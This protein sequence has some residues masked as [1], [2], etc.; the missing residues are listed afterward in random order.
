M[1][2][3]IVFVLFLF[4]F[5]YSFVHENVIVNE[6]CN[7]GFHPSDNL[8]ISTTRL[9][10]YTSTATA[11]T[12]S[13]RDGVPIAH[14]EAPIIKLWKRFQLYFLSNNSL[15]STSC[16]N[17][18]NKF[19]KGLKRNEYW[20]FKMLDATAKLPSGI[21]SG[22]VNQFG[23][24]DGC[25]SVVEAQY[26]LAE[27]NLDSV[28]SEHY[29]QYKNL[30]HSYYPFK[31]TFEDPQ[32]RVPDFTTIKWGIC[33]PSE[34]T[35]KE[36]EV[37]LK[38]EFG[39]K[40]K[41]RENM[42]RRANQGSRPLSFGDYVAR[43]FFMTL[44]LVVIVSTL[45]AN[46]QEILS[47]NEGKFM[48]IL[49]SFA[50]Q[51][52]WKRLKHIS[53][54]DETINV[55]NNNNNCTKYAKKEDGEIKAVHGIRAISAIALLMCHKSLALMYNPYINRT[56]TIEVFSQQWTVI[57]RTAIVYTDCF[58]LISGLLTTH[59]VLKDLQLHGSLRFLDRLRNRIFR[60]L[61]NIVTLILFCTYILPRTN[62]GPLWPMVV[63]HH[64]ELCKQHMW[65]NFLFIHN[66]FGF[67]NMC[68]THT[69]QVGIDMQ[70]FVFSYI[71]ALCCYNRKWGFFVTG[72]IW[73]SS[74]ILRYVA[75]VK[76]GLSHMIYFG[77]P[78]QKMFDTANMSYILPT[79]RATIYTTGIFM[80]YTLKYNFNLS[81]AQVIFGWSIAVISMLLA[82]MGPFQMID[83]EYVYNSRHAALFGVVSPMLCG[84]CLSWV[85]YAANNGYAGWIG[86]FLHWKGFRYFTKI[87]YSFYL[88]QFPVF[89]Y[90]VGIQKAASEFTS[91]ELLHF[92]ETTAT[93]LISIALTVCVEM[94]F[95]NI[96]KIIFHS[97]SS[98]DKK[99][100]SAHK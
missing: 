28:W 37:S 53:N 70:L 90:N 10:N 60:L 2:P 40:A 100:P 78:I 99:P 27:L 77:I 79:H 49:F 42:C 14:I 57:G 84:V 71:L 46:N 73:T 35:A 80:A 7:S 19:Q 20:A 33:I 23:D 30:A 32:H 11:R 44:L 72:V 16:Q 15:L 43:A 91:H 51:S 65:K 29:V 56:A 38:T 6:Q 39:I 94:P 52:N 68:L 98:K 93:I 95:Q 4:D 50:L 47:N 61:P 89:F 41:V 24:Y 13:K 92:T 85:I 22:N 12:N 5:G 74:A 21:L 48:R 18:T 66:Y 17:A 8:I 87:S 64:S 26:C 69:H 83:K 34:C 55:N 54:G 88:I 67:E 1:T 45:L 59:S 25:L 62:S 36:L 82:V 9:R 76:Y 97:R 96:E 58:M 75:T 31:G 86:D 63:E 81:K 3:F